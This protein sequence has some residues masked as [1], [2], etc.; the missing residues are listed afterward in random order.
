MRFLPVPYDALNA[1]EAADW[2]AVAD[3]YYRAHSLRWKPFE[4]TERSLMSRWR[5][6]GRKCWRLLATLERLELLAIS[7]GSKRS[8]S[9]VEVY[10]PTQEE[11]QHVGQH[12]GQHNGAATMPDI[13]GSEAQEAAQEAALLT[14]AESRDETRRKTNTA[15]F[16]RAAAVYNG[17]VRPKMG[18]RR[19]TLKRSKGNGAELAKAIKAHGIDPVVLVLEWWAASTHRRAQFYRDPDNG[20]TLTTMRR[21]FA[22]LLDFA[23]NPP[24]RRGEYTGPTPE[25]AAENERRK[26]LFLADRAKRQAEAK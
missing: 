25:A 3:L 18:L 16:E 5:M 10:C 13:A 4:V 23:E 22:A 14:R 9:L 2:G 11:V 26:Q 20:C 6:S 24:R 15:E 17:R 8:P 19:T 21:N 12:V 1:V 7:K